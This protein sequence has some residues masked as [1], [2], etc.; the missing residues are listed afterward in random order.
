MTDKKKLRE[1]ANK[2]PLM[3]SLHVIALLNELE[4]KDVLI[5]AIVDNRFKC[6]I[7][8]SAECPDGLLNWTDRAI[9]ALSQSTAPEVE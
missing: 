4:A 2:C 7:P 6:F 3:G 1:L 9:E 5:K 8:E